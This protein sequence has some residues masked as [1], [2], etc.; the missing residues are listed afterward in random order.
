MHVRY[1]LRWPNTN[2]V[3]LHNWWEIFLLFTFFVCPFFL[4]KKK[5][6]DG[7]K[8]K[9]WLHTQ[10][11]MTKMRAHII[12]KYL[13]N[14]CVLVLGE[15]IK[16]CNT[17]TWL[18]RIMCCSNMSND[19]WIIWNMNQ[20]Y[21]A[22]NLKCFFVVSAS[23]FDHNSRRLIHFPIE[24]ARESNKKNKIPLWTNCTHSPI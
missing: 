5:K 10:P 1:R 6:Y 21:N 15:R 13:L 8:S 9:H 4:Q 20:Q 23:I 2:I 19:N 17:F 22:I 7:T 3:W 24:C 14:C 12:E 18:Y 11:I 16:K